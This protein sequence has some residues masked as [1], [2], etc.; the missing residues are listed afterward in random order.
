V[1][2]VPERVDVRFGPLTVCRFGVG[3]SYDPGQAAVIL[4]R[5][6]I[7]VT[8]DLNLGSAGAT[9]LTC[10]LTHDYVAINA[11]YTT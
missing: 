11:E 2:F 9:V 3:A 1:Q 8:V 5:H 6:D 10:D 7:D 4:S